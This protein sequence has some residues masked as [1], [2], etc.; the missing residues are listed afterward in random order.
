MGGKGLTALRGSRPHLS[1]QAG[2]VD[3]GRTTSYLPV[4]GE[5]SEAPILV[6]KRAVD[7]AL[8]LERLPKC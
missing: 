2:R 4:L 6:G 1:A 5:I 8:I 7:E 3:D